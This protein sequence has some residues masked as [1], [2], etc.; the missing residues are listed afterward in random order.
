MKASP[1]PPAPLSDGWQGGKGVQMH[2]QSCTRLGIRNGTNVIMMI[3][4]SS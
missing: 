1:L 4:M 3:M 2:T